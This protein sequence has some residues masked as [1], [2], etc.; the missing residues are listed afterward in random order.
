MKLREHNFPPKF[1]IQLHKYTKD[2][3]PPPPPPKR[4]TPTEIK[5]NKCVKSLSPH[6]QHFVFSSGVSKSKGQIKSGKI[7][8]DCEQFSILKHLGVTH[9]YRSADLLERNLRLKYDF[10]YKDYHRGVQNMQF[11][12]EK[13]KSI[14]AKE[15]AILMLRF[16]CQQKAP[17]FINRL[18]SDQEA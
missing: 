18:T 11:R 3:L 5:L 2:P 9:R 15:K 13:R 17:V 12:V 6:L 16:R 7:P 1:W 14:L 4:R 8:L 10:R